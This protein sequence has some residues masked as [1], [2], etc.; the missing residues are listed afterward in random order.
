MDVVIL[1]SIYFH[2]NYYYYIDA[3]LL[4]NSMPV[5]HQVSKHF[6]CY[7]SNIQE[8]VYYLYPKTKFLMIQRKDTMGFTDFVRGKYPEEYSKTLPIFLNEMTIKEKNNLLTK[9][10]D[11]IWGDLWVNHDS[12]CFKNE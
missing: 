5:L 4:L 7:D 3:S 8:Y 12:K 1:Q 11:E 6:K 9:S 10:F 2:C